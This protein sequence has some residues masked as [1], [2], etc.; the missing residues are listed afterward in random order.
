VGTIDP[1]NPKD[2]KPVI[3]MGLIVTAI[4]AIPVLSALNI[5]PSDDSQFG[6]PR[7]LVAFIAG[8]FPAIGLF[9]ILMGLRNFTTDSKLASFMTQIAIGFLLITLACFIGGGAIFLTMQ[10][11]HPTGSSSIS[12]GPVSFF[13]PGSIAKYIDR[14]VIGFVALL[15]DAIALLFAG[16]LL[17]ETIRLLR[18]HEG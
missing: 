15:L 12:I 2:A 5:I 7:W 14:I 17:V 18:K 4:G 10:F 6:A 8:A 16:S 13:L 11:F 1:A 9:L 3:A